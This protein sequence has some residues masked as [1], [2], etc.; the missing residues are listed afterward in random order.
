MSYRFHITDVFTDKPFGGNQL[1]VLP[2]ARGLT[3]EQMQTIAREFNFSESTFVF[4]ADDSSHSRKVRIFTPGAELPFAGHPTVGTAFVLAATGEIDLDGDETRIIFEEGV[5]PVPVMIRA[6][7]GKPFFSQLTAA[8]VPE[9]VS[10]RDDAATIA[11]ALSLD[12]SDVLSSPAAIEAWSVGVPFLFVPLRDISAV[13]RARVDTLA[14]DAAFGSGG[15]DDVFLFAQ[16]G[17]VIRARMFAPSLG[18]PEDPATG[19]AVAALGGYLAS[20][21]AAREGTLRYT[22][23]QGVEMG[24]PSLLELEVDISTGGVSAVRVGGASVLVA[25]GELHVP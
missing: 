16:E 6:R 12:S 23:H 11:K 19:S 3:S 21:S 10:T 7:G 8:R 1:A 17:D 13:Q 25:S 9:K 14:W 18:V 20:R 2:D 4:P 5:G 15:T 24:R 22:V